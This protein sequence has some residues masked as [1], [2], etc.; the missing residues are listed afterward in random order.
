M[1]KYRKLLNGEKVLESSVSVQMTIDSKCPKKWAF[2]DMET[3]DIWVHKSR[4][5]KLSK[6]KN[7][8]YTFFKADDKALRAIENIITKKIANDMGYNECIS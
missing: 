6:Y 8:S 4:L 1:K 3:G 2:V 5:S 7:S